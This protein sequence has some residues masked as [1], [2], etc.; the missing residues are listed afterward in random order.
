VQ[1]GSAGGASHQ[2]GDVP[3]HTVPDRRVE[4]RQGAVDLSVDRALLR[5]TGRASEGIAIF[6]GLELVDATPFVLHTALC[7]TRRRIWFAGHTVQC[8]G[9]EILTAICVVSMIGALGFRLG[10]VKG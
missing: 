1:R 3:S 7:N 4:P 10:L 5:D 2:S 8:S 9:A 6:F